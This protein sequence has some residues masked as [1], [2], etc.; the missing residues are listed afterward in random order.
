LISPK[1]IPAIPGVSNFHLLKIYQL[2]PQCDFTTIITTEISSA[3]VAGYVEC[4]QRQLNRKLR[5]VWLSHAGG[6]EVYYHQS[7]L[8]KKK[9]LKKFSH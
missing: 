7:N 6:Y 5:K 4:N 1:L 2:L 9:N 8:C 3:H